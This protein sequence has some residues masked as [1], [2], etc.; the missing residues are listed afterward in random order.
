[1]MPGSL[2]DRLR[3]LAGDNAFLGDRPTVTAVA[4]LALI[5]YATLGAIVPEVAEH[6]RHVLLLIALWAF[7]A[8]RRELR[9]SPAFW[10]LVAACAIALLSWGLSL[11]TH[12]QWAERSPKLDR[13]T[14]LLWGIPIAYAIGG[15]ARRG[16]WMWIAAA[17]GL[18]LAPWISG[19]G[20]AEIARGLRGER[21]DFGLHNAEHTG[22]YYSVLGLG[23]LATLPGALRDRR[24]R[25]AMALL[26]SVALVAAAAGIVFAQ[27]RSMWLGLSAALMLMGWLK[28]FQLTRHRL[29]RWVCAGGVALAAAPLLA[30]LL[31][32]GAIDGRVSAEGDTIRSILSGQYSA[33]PFDSTGIR[34]HTWHASFDWIA[35]RPLLGWGGKGRNLVIAES[36]NLPESVKAAFRHLHNSYLD[37]TA[38]YGL[39]GLALLLTLWGWLIFIALRATRR[40]TLPPEMLHFILC[41]MV[42]WAIVNAFE[43]FIFYSSG[44][45]IFSLIG[46]YILSCHW[47]TLPVADPRERRGADDISGGP[48]ATAVAERQT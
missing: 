15:Q 21:V 43:S 41:F 1:M 46:G 39:A 29:W 33:I 8:G 19:D 37:I 48:S 32:L 11:L 13:L 2:P 16:R 27:T 4:A 14:T 44:I 45:Y 20:W 24:R 40:G 31:H 38:N 30:A 7:F 12:P 10:L 23:L 47:Q 5:A 36:E 34:I 35:E 6:C 17:V 9:A 28:G 3:P 18:L 42:L 22:L 25:L 26:W